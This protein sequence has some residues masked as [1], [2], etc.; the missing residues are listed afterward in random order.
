M[1]KLRLLDVGE[2]FDVIVTAN[3]VPDPKPSPDPL[4]LVRMGVK[5]NC[6]AIED[7]EAGALGAHSAGCTVIGFNKFDPERRPVP[8]SKVTVSRWDDLS[9]ESLSQ[10]VSVGPGIDGSER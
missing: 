1:G 7:S 6:I 4:T 8:H 9:Y 2:F 3:D 5:A 10:L